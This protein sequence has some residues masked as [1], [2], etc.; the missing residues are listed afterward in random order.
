MTF[1]KDF[2]LS[3][4]A[5]EYQHKIYSEVF[6]GIEV[7]RYQRQNNENGHILDVLYHIDVRVITDSGASFLGQEKCLR[8]RWQSK[9]TF[10]IEYQQNSKSGRRW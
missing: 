7:E 8:N 10:T 4:K 3:L 2:E 6:D 5:Q 1:K 9:N